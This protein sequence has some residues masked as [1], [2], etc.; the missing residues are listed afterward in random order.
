[1]IRVCVAVDH[2]TDVLDPQARL[3]QFRTS[4]RFGVSATPLSSSTMPDWPTTAFRYNGSP[5]V[6]RYSVRS[7]IQSPA[8]RFMPGAARVGA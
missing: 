1:V 4:A 8:K 3:L 6:S 2:E 7:E 5:Q